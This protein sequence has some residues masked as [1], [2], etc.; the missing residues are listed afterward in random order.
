[1]LDSNTMYYITKN[2]VASSTISSDDLVAVV[3]DMFADLNGKIVTTQE[4]YEDLF[5]YSVANFIKEKEKSD[6]V[7]LLKEE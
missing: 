5:M 6:K 1:M 7:K 2:L 4:Q 3:F